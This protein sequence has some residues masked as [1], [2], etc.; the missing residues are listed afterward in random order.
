MSSLT[1]TL[2]LTWTAIPLGETV[3]VIT[4]VILYRK[5]A[6]DLKKQTRELTGKAQT[7][8]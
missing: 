4:A 7:R 8:S 6:K 1:G 5:M 2:K 3:T